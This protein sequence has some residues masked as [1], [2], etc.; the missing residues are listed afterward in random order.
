MAERGEGIRMGVVMDVVSAG[1]EPK[2]TRALLAAAERNTLVEGGEVMIL[3]D[4]AGPA[5]SAL[6]ASCGYR[7]TSERY[8]MTAWPKDRC[9]PGSWTANLENWRFVFADHDAF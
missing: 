9:P 5:H 6:F 4:G 1:D 8:Q 7:A 2:T 3:L